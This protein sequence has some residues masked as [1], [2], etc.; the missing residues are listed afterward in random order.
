[1]NGDEL[2]TLFLD[3]FESKGHKVMSSSSLVPHSD[4]T[5]LLTSAGM[6]QMKPYF[7]GEETPSSLR[8]AS[9]QKCFRAT[10]I[11]LVGDASHCTFFEM[12][13]N[14]SVGD[15]FKKETIAW[16]WEFIVLYLKLPPE[17]LW[18]SVFLDDDEAFSYWVETGIPEERIQRF[19]EEENFW[20]PVGD[21]GPCGPDTEIFYDFG[22]EYS[23][24]KP[25]CGPNCDC[26]RF[27]EIG[28][29]VF[30]QYNQDREGVR[31]LL[32]KPSVDTGMGLERNLAVVQGKQ[33]I[34]ETDQY[35][36]LIKCIANLSGKQYGAADESDT[37]MRV[38]A[39][40]SRGIAFLIGDGVM[41]SNE[42]R[43]YV[44]RR[45]IRRAAL[46]GRRLGL[47]KPFLTEMA[48]TTI[49]QMGNTYPEL[50]QRQDF[51][52]K[53][54]ELE[55][56]GFG[57][58][59]NTGLELIE[60]VLGERETARTGEISGEH[61][62]RLYDTFGFPPEL[63]SEIALGRGFSV[64]LKS[65]EK[66]MEKQRERAKA[67]QK[68][69]LIGKIDIN[70]KLD[71][72]P[73]VFTGYS[74]YKQKADILGILV[75]IDS[76]DSV[77]V[78]QEASLILDRTPFYGEMGGQVGD[79]GEIR[80]STGRFS[81]TGTVWITPDIIAHRGNVIEGSFSTGEE[82][83]AEVERE[84]RL[85]IARNHT[86]THLLQEALRKVLG[87]YIQQRG[88]LVTPDHFRF[89][90]S[91]LVAMTG[92][93]IDRVQNI[94]NDNIRQDL[95]VYDEEIPYRE[96]IEAGVIALFDEKYGDVVRV[97][98]VG[99]P[100]LSAELCGGTHISTT[101]EIGY[102]HITSESSIGAGL[103]RIEAVTGKGAEKYINRS[104]QDLKEIAGQLDSEP[105]E[106]VEKVQSL[107]TELKNERK[108][109][110]DLESQLARKDAGEI[111]NKA[112]E[113]NGIKVLAKKVEAAGIDNLRE[114]SDLLNCKLGDTAIVVLG[115]ALEDKPAFV[116][117][118][119]PDLVKQGYKAGEIVKKVAGV[120]GGSG[121][122]KPSI[123]QGGGKDIKK[124]DEALRE[125]KKYIEE[126]DSS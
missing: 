74:K 52:L 68:F 8:L 114:M 56:A 124:I 41:P 42:G 49:G 63:T 10:D 39:E 70:K 59:L 69:D 29:L 113:I 65:F 16:A 88:S 92:E 36:P 109:I 62:F 85:D 76:V 119:S 123:A 19:G 67:S 87:E 33:T 64:D 111:E 5:L 101:G 96:A 126:R 20:G 38:V 112:E 71:I 46:F 44:L 73:T 75:N 103:R 48:E 2:R 4:P 108:R 66:E 21:S 55:E 80:S 99:K 9:C 97:L 35:T 47:D 23:C 22:E 93:E 77:E 115:A 83:E 58:T 104:L 102:F 12:L 51:I 31:S 14:F 34:Y 37:A 1:M 17:R 106:L 105:D 27:I 60:A 91:H 94:I 100:L 11:E 28:T 40:H 95:P 45:L 50:K 78:E 3:F 18:A 13:G 57:E 79:T 25:A 26:S 24:G 53:I 89:D 90:F 120:A 86:A 43:G 6:V 118:V 61:V 98:K 110:Q 117:T 7:L 107:S 125:V 84:R 72:K 121:G 116:A 54:I 30:M 82:V 32:P 81:V 15:Y 122:G